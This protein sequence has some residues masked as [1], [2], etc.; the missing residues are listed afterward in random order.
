M[1]QKSSAASEPSYEFNPSGYLLFAKSFS[2]QAISRIDTLAFASIEKD[3]AK[4][5]V[6][7]LAA[8]FY[9]FA[10]SRDKTMGS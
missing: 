3:E 8:E 5:R 2:M 10:A 4:L 1:D 7:W 9:Y 6:S